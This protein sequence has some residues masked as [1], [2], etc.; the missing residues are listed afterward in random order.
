[1]YSDLT[2]THLLRVD[3][4]FVHSI[5]RVQFHLERR[6]VSTAKRPIACVSKKIKEK[7]QLL[8]IIFDFSKCNRCKSFN[9]SEKSS[10]IT[11]ISDR[12]INRKV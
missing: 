10:K 3:V 1:M 6:V 12:K 8:V 5:V 4:F 2:L 9:L 11:R 7:L